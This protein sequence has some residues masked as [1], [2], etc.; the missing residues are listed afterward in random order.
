MTLKDFIEKVNE[1]AKVNI[2]KAVGMVEAY[3]MINGTKFWILARRVTFTCIEHGH[4]DAHD[5]LVWAEEIEAGRFEM[6]N[7]F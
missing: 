5:A 1:I 4:K 2:D 6:I 7:N 3:N